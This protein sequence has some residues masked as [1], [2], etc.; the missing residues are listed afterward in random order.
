MIV[1]KIKFILLLL[2]ILNVYGSTETQDLLEKESEYETEEDYSDYNE[3]DYDDDDNI[4]ENDE[5]G[6]D[7]DD[8]P[9]FEV[10]DLKKVRN[11]CKLSVNDMVIPLSRYGDAILNETVR[12]Y[13]SDDLFFE[14]NIPKKYLSEPI[15][16]R[17]NGTQIDLNDFFFN[18]AVDKKMVN[19]LTRISVTTIVNIKNQTVPQIIQFPIVVLGKLFFFFLLV[20]FNID[21]FLYYR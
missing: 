16:W 1:L 3:Y 20:L 19:N 12:A 6:M 10:E 8:D 2:L 14:C 5:Y 9:D 4:L 13:F 21:L 18:L 17:L 7:V 15:S 11:L